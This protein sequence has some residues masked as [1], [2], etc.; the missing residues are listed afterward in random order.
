MTPH[1]LDKPAASKLTHRQIAEE[2]GVSRQLV[3][4][5]LRG[6][7]R[8]SDE[9]RQRILDVAKVNGYDQYSNGAARS[10]AALRHGKRTRTGLMAVLF[11]PTFQGRP[12]SSVPFFMPFFDG[13]ESEA[14]EHDLDL[15]LC[16]LRSAG[17]PRLVREGHVDGVVCLVTDR[18]ELEPFKSLQLPF[19][20]I[21]VAVGRE[22]EVADTPYLSIDARSGSALATRHLI[23]LGH[24]NIAFLGFSGLPE[25]KKKADVTSFAGFRDELSSHGIVPDPAMVERELSSVSVQTGHEA[26][27]RLLARCTEGGTLPFTG[28]V[29]DNDLLAM[30]AIR[31]LEEAGHTVPAD[32]SVVGFDD[33]STQYA[34]VPALTSIRFPREEMGRRAL[35]LL[36]QASAAGED[37][38]ATL[39]T[40]LTHEVFPVELVQRD[41]TRRLT[42]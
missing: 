34:F 33:V 42:A 7:G 19:V 10:L 28:L 24:R 3:G 22:E 41:S 18:L 4:F 30:G 5:A 32:V 38:P 23:E 8:M 13:L 20:H 12:L 14:I 39:A 17:L 2:L 26:M 6:E 37:R 25:A 15:M 40:G 1:L 21:L 9:I 31:A 11:P 35:R 36:A 27:Q 16:P 29:C